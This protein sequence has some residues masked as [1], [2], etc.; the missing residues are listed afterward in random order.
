M[1]KLLQE[2]FH[3][4]WPIRD[5]LKKN[6]R[7]P[8]EH[9]IDNLKPQRKDFVCRGRRD[10][11]TWC[12]KAVK[13]ADYCPECGSECGLIIHAAGNQVSQF[14][15]LWC[16][17][18]LLIVVEQDF[19]WRINE[20]SLKL[21]CKD[22]NNINSLCGVREQSCFCLRQLYSYHNL[23]MHQQAILQT[24]SFLQLLKATCRR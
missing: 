9:L 12:E 4:W 5:M 15:P 2:A 1:S 24:L 18:M 3:I 13:V 23:I 17:K 7:N 20:A 14:C 11:P 19:L 22:A 16:W 6:V 21:Q 10:I 8:Y